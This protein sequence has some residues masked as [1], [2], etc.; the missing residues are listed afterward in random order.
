MVGVE[1]YG[2]LLALE[3]GLE[4]GSCH[5]TE[6]LADEAV[7]EE[8]DGC[9]QKGQHVG[10][11]QHDVDQPRVLDGCSV[12][13]VEDHD[14][15]GGPERGKDGGDGEQDGSGLPRGIATEAEIALSPK[16]V[17]NDGVQDEEDGAGHQVHGEAV[18]PDKDVMHGGADV[19]FGP[20][21]RPPVVGD[22]GQEAGDVNTQNDFTG[23][24]WVGNCVVFEWV[25]DGNIP[26]NC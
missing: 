16:L 7:E 23:P 4:G 22:T 17:H 24:G 3:Q 8:V 11:V 19:V 21:V 12:E 2:L 18:D 9:V 20:D 15:A 10:N 6:A 26:V 25:T 14:D 5:G 13:V 1:L